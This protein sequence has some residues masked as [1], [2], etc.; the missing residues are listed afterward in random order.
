MNQ[1]KVTLYINSWSNDPTE[2]IAEGVQQCLEEG[3]EL[4]CINTVKYL[5]DEQEDKRN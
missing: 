5:N 2:W 4:T 3:E 1:F